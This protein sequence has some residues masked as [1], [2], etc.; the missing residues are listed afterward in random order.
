MIADENEDGV[1][2]RQP[3]D[4]GQLNDPH[5][6]DLENSNKFGQH[7]CQVVVLHFAEL[8]KQLGKHIP[9]VNVDI[10]FVS[11][12][13]QELADIH[14]RNP[15][16]IVSHCALLLVVVEVLVGVLEIGSLRHL[17]VGH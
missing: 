11:E 17:C 2:V 15:V 5:L 1:M 8:G 3:L 6:L 9:H 7:L 4:V 16:W 10:L 14:S 12:L 13:C